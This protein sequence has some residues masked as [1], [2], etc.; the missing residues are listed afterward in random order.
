M[1]EDDD[2]DE[3]P[4][5]DDNPEHWIVFVIFFGWAIAAIFWVIN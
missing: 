5:E 3:Y 1:T 4:P 2:F